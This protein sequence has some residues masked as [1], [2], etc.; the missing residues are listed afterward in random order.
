M[1]TQWIVYTDG[2]VSVINQIPVLP[3]LYCSSE[4]VYTSDDGEP[5]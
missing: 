1:C 3:E 2:G 5:I 4:D